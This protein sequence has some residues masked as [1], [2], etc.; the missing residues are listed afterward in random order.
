MQ[1]KISGY[2]VSESSLD[3]L[4]MLLL[5][6]LSAYF[7]MPFFVLSCL[8]CCGQPLALALTCLCLPIAS[9]RS[10]GIGAKYSKRFWM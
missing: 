8:H 2:V 6:S 7:S 10:F 4:K 3:F 9:T 5:E 1:V